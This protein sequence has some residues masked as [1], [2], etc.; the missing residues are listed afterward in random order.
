MENQSAI[1]SDL[2]LSGANNFSKATRIGSMFLDHVIMCVVFFA[3]SI[4]SFTFS[5]DK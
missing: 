4:P 5:I 3:F 2:H 1:F